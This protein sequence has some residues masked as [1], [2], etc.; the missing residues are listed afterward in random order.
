MGRPVVDI[1]GKRYGNRVVLHR[2]D[3]VN[4]SGHVLWVSLCELCGKTSTTQKANIQ[5]SK[6]CPCVKTKHG[7]SY[8]P[9]YG[10]WTAM[11][12]RCSSPNDRAY[13]NYGGRGIT[14]C[15]RWRLFANFIN[16]VGYRPSNKHTIERTDNNGNYTPDNVVWATRL[17]QGLNRR[18]NRRLSANG[19]TMTIREWTDF[20]GAPKH[21]I[22]KRLS[23]GWSTERALF[24]PR[25]D[26]WGNECANPPVARVASAGVAVADMLKGT[27][28]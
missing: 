1:T 26:R 6:S 23:R 28:D 21:S 22:S 12:S 3:G 13:K 11:L 17:E 16:D 20:L 25:T 10:V 15:D 7:G 14:V 27:E 19:M 5:K 24:A 8:T 2:A 4:S 18:N 9:E